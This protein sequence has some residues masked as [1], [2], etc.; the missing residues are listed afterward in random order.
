MNKI[1]VTAKTVE[2][3][4]EKGL[5]ELNTTR[6]RVEIRVIEQPSR[7][8]LG[9]IGAKDAKVELER[10]FDP[11]EEAITFLHEVLDVLVPGANVV[12]RQEDDYIVFD[13]SGKQLGII[14]GKRGQTLDSLQYLVNLVANRY[15]EQYLKIVLDAE[16]YREKR[17][18]TLEN[19]AERLAEKVLRTQKSV[20]LEPMSA[21]ERKIIHTRLQNHPDVS[22]YSKGEEPNRYV[23]IDLK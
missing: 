20:R 13:I 18:K 19:L 23:V 9:L 4:V 7:G 14:I 11:V 3:A 21:L 12:T 1:T 16:N 8:L 15:S 5:K 6:D 10:I 17:Q 2:E 22:T